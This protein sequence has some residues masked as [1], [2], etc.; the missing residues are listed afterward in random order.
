[1][2]QKTGTLFVRLN[3]IKYWPISKLFSLSESGENL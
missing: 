3:F 2:A 1:V